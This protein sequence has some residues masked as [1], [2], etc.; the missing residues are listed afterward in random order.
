MFSWP[1]RRRFSHS[2][3]LFTLIGIVIG[4][5]ATW[6]VARQPWTEKAIFAPPKKTAYTALS[7]EELKNRSAQLAAAIH[8]LARSFYEEDNR[9]R[10][11]ADE[12][13]AGTKSP[14][15]QERLRKAWI[16]ESAKLHDTFMQRYQDNFWE[17]AVL[18]RDAIL[19]RMGSVAGTRNP[20]F[21]HP[22]NILGVEQVANSLELMSKSL[23]AKA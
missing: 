22:T 20:L 11:A 8:G 10:I 17:D 19:A 14:G 5:S 18:L 9:L 15:E 4:S 2:P 12:K 1:I 21:Q 6:F 23:P 3:F 7:N 16:D 13:L